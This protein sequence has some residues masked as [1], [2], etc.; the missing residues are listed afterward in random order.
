MTVQNG[1]TRDNTHHVLGHQLDALKE[2]MRKVVERVA[3]TPTIA[4]ARIQSLAG[5]VGKMVKAHPIVAVGAAVGIGYLV[6]RLV[7]R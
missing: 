3:E 5:Q 1:N 6:V 4:K 7:R 2:G